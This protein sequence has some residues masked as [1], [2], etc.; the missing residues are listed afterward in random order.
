MRYELL[1]RTQSLTLR[2]LTPTEERRWL[3]YN[4]REYYP[5]FTVG[6][7]L[8]SS[9]YLLDQG[10]H[11]APLTGSILALWAGAH[12]AFDRY[13]AR[14]DQGLKALAQ[15]SETGLEEIETYHSVATHAKSLKMRFTHPQ[16][17]L[18]SGPRLKNFNLQGR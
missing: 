9:A 7:P 12:Y 14:K 1:P 10:L 3:F 13:L 2:G 15:H 17:K 16:L 18:T 6:I 5:L 8:F 11:Q 4:R